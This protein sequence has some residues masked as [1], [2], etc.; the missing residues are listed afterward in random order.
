MSGEYRY[1][2]YGLTLSSPRPLPLL[3][4]EVDPE[5]VAGIVLHFAPVAIPP[6]E[7]LRR[8]RRLS[9][10]ADG[11][12]LFQAMHGARFLIRAGCEITIDLPA[13]TPDAELHALLCGPPLGWLMCQRG[14]PPLHAGVVQIG[15]CAVAV[16]GD[17][18]AGKSTLCRA[19]IGR[20][21]GLIADDQA[22]IDAATRQVQPGYP[23]MKLWHATALQAGDIV[24]PGMRVREA[25][26]KYY[27][28]MPQAFRPQPLALGLVVVVSP[29][30]A[31][32]QLEQAR[33]PEAAVLL[34]RCL[35][36]PEFSR[37]PEAARTAFQWAAAIAGAVP[38]F[39]LER[40]NNAADLPALA[41]AVETLAAQFGS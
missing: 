34:L 12:G 13:G 35:Y 41:A 5:R 38:V 36:R 15:A 1:R 10:Y 29:G 22:V 23:A 19:L 28:P 33:A 31:G 8:M 9:V 11:S 25:L 2:I 39:R 14:Q 40:T 7:P 16:A 30:Q 6:Q 4:P 26:E 32:Q 21:H 20:G 37:E 27:I 3:W 18:G 24:Q 17:S